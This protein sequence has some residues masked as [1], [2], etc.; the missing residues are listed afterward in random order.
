MKLE[1]Y[2]GD[3][4]GDLFPGD[5]LVENFKIP[6][7]TDDLVRRPRLQE[8]LELGAAGPLTLVSAPAGTGKTV[9]VAAWASSGQASGP[10]TWITLEARDGSR[11]R[12]R[13]SLAHGLKSCGVAIQP[14]PWALSDH[15]DDGFVDRLASALSKRTEP[16]FVVLDFASDI[17]A[18][19]AEDLDALLRRSGRWL[20]LVV[21]TRTDRA[22]PLHRYRLAGTVVELRNEDLAFRLDEA[23]ELLTR[24]GMELSETALR[25]IVDRTQGWAAGIRFAAL[26]MHQR[27]DTDLERT[28]HEFRGDTGDV[29]EYLRGEVLDRQP[30][31]WRQLLLQT[32]IVDVLQPGLSE[33]LAGRDA[34][35]AL[36]ALARGN[37]FLDEL[38]ASP[39]FY[40]YQPLFRELLRAQLTY[41]SPAKVPELHRSAAAWMADH[42]FV[43]AAVRHAAEG[44]D[45][46]AAA[47]NLI[48]GLAIG[49][50]L[51]PSE[52]AL[53]DVLTPLPSDAGG[54]F[55]SLVRA[56]LAIAGFDLER[57]EE[58]LVRA[59]RELDSAGISNRSAA[60][61]SLQLVRMT[62]A[63]FVAN[64]EVAL[65]AAAR[66]EALL[67]QHAPDRLD[68][69]PELPILIESSK[70]A[71]WLAKGRL[72]EAMEAFSAGARA[73]DRPGSE[74]LLI[75][76]LGHLA[77]LAAMRGQLRRA[78]DLAGR[79]AEIQGAPHLAET[80]CPS[81]AVAK[82]WV[83]TELYDLSS[84]RR[85]AQRATELVADDPDPT[86]RVALALV[87]SRV[88]RARGDVD[89]ALARIVTA[90][91]DGPTPAWLQD[92]LV[93]EEAELLI[94]NG[95]PELAAQ[96]VEGLY[97]PGSPESALVLARA[98]M[99]A[100]AVELPTTTLRR[101]AASTPTRV[102]GW[103]LEA[104]RLLDHGELLRATEALERALRLAAPE[105]L[106]RPFREASPQVRRLLRW[107]RN[108][109]TEHGWLGAA[110][111]DDD[112][113]PRRR[114]D[115]E[116][117]I[118]L[119]EPGKRPIP[120]ALTEKELEVLGHLAGWLTTEEIA[121]AMFVSVNTVRT[122]VRHILRKLGS[123][124]RHEAVRHAG[125]LGI[126]QG[127]TAAETSARPQSGGSDQFR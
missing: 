18:D 124:R 120:E 17:S 35:R 24:T 117:D 62:Y 71:A 14:L 16:V 20:R 68:E 40:R 64:V 126:L 39:G 15:V 127:W 49:R 110:T 89:A 57:C 10:I 98:R 31:D 25:A 115:A 26:S 107:D 27:K 97:E 19:V 60:A 116:P 111:L 93:I 22:L 43:E 95:Q 47:R 80:A 96:M 6:A 118:S 30:A 55:A 103:L 61:L 37:V 28:A 56:A 59:E 23:R 76:C 21:V 105:R 72:D 4:K 63:A 123:S 94:V 102:N 112:R 100:G 121:G 119:D 46:E 84:A 91:S 58:H 88:K 114:R 81:A 77:M 32:S 42:G 70:G 101:A 73:A 12:F 13:S 79:V 34:Q 9:A 54:V 50:L 66:A 36:G 106:R 82:A 104:T 87:D 78:N 51:L 45:W 113:P 41:E 11:T 5:L 83:N 1:V 53:T 74:G 75:H 90:R 33:S 86:T 99:S 85:H 38:P 3:G 65:G 125:E 92:A 48:D 108:L 7:Q 44:G 122:H 109:T 8:H 69:H 29:A 52:D 67:Q 2:E